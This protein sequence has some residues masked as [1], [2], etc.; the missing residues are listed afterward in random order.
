MIW[1]LRAFLSKNLGTKLSSFATRAPMATGS[2]A[3][4]KTGSEWSV[5]S[6][7]QPKQPMSQEQQHLA[8]DGGDT[9]RFLP[10]YMTPQSSRR[11]QGMSNTARG[12]QKVPPRY[13]T[14]RMS[15][16]Q[17]KL[18]ALSK[19][20]PTQEPAMLKDQSRKPT[21]DARFNTPRYASPR[22]TSGAM[23]RRIEEQAKWHDE[24]MRRPPKTT[25]RRHRRAQTSRP[26][27]R[28]LREG[29]DQRPSGGKMS[30]TARGESSTKTKPKPP[31]KIAPPDMP[32]ETGSKAIERVN[33][34][35]RAK[36][37][38]STRAKADGALAA[39]EAMIRAEEKGED[40]V[41]A[42]P[43]PPP[44]KPEEPW[45]AEQKA[46]AEAV[47]QQTGRS[48]LSSPIRWDAELHTW[49]GPDGEPIL[50]SRQ[51]SGQ[52][53]SYKTGVMSMSAR[54]PRQKQLW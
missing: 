23:T 43:P 32:S 14:P 48:D 51:S 6:S 27:P 44:P 50:Q 22:F 46:K 13:M 4:Q 2:A 3:I 5:W 16:R 38:A 20:Q 25:S 21:V 26:A 45:R 8:D 31:Q 33:S 37:D 47:A 19:Q 35:G 53:G 52:A 10:R 40:L 34:F 18:A 7:W 1:T 42:Q 12:K 36:F 54:A 30:K 29:A 11:A 28:N 9:S 39:V 17:Q 49:V 24:A 41:P 15:S